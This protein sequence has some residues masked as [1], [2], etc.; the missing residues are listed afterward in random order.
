VCTI[1]VVTFRL[2]AVAVGAAL[3]VA[4]A[5]GAA[6][7]PSTSSALH[8]TLAGSSRAPVSGQPWRFVLRATDAA[9]RPVRASA[10]IYATLGGKPVDTIGLFA[11]GGVLRRGYR[12]S[13]TLVGAPATLRAAVTAGGTTTNVSFPVRVVGWTGA[14]R[15]AVRVVPQDHSPRAGRGWHFAVHARSGRNRPVG[16]SVVVRVASRGH[17]VDTVGWFGFD[18]DLRGTY[19]WPKALSGSFAVFQAK[20]VGPGGTRI[21][22]IPVRVS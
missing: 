13:S 10:R 17:I 9:G 18:G 11:F 6:A 21:V 19:S 14:P 12:W 3:C 22:G 1:R 16:T 7:A 2:P 5:G 20:V 15:F 4:V 8:V